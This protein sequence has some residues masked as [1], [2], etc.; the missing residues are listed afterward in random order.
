VTNTSPAVLLAVWHI[1]KDPLL[2]QKIRANL[3]EQFGDRRMRDID[4]KELL[5]VPLLQSVYAETLR[6]YTKVYVMVNSPQSD[7]A[8]GRWAIPKQHIGILN[9]SISH[10]D[11]QFWN[12]KNGLHPVDSFWAERFLTYPSDRSSG[13]IN[14]A[15]R[16]DPRSWPENPENNGTPYFST[17]GLD[18]SWF[19]Y[20]G[21]YSICPGRHLAKNVILLTCATLVSEYEIEFS[22]EP[23]RLDQRRHGLGLIGPKENVSYRMKKRE[24]N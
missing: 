16:E 17:K 18:S 24:K 4:P 20:G 7:V 1:F 23:L 10:H 21:G 14:P 15:I 2:L 3:E 12:T 6:L 19:P 11:S 5:R 8:L 9:S 13:P 22:S